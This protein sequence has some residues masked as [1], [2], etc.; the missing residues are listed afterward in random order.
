MEWSEK[1]F[2]SKK[3]T[4]LLFTELEKVKVDFNLPKELK[5]QVAMIGLTETDIK[6]LHVLQPIVDKYIDV[7]VEN[8]YDTITKEPSLI[9]IIEKHCNVERL[10]LTLNKHVLQIFSGE[11]NEEYVNHRKRIAHVHVRIGLGTKWYLN[12]FQHLMN[13]IYSLLHN[14]IED[15]EELYDAMNSIQ[16]IFS[17]EQQLVLESYENKEKAIQN[18]KDVEKDKIQSHMIVTAQE[19]SSIAEQTSSSLQNLVYQ[20]K[21]IEG[22]TDESNNLIQQV[23]A[24]SK[25]G[26]LLMEKDNESAKSLKENIKELDVEISDL[27]SLSKKVTNVVDVVS[28]IA[29][30]INLLALNATIES[31]HA[32]EHGKGFAVVANE[33][34]NLSSLTKKSTEDIA[35]LITEI[36]VQIHNVNHSVKKFNENIERNEA[37]TE[38]TLRFFNEIVQSVQQSR[39]KSDVIFQEIKESDSALNQINTSTLKVSE[40]ADNLLNVK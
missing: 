25:E 19:L 1:M 8:F 40:T 7:L 36:S 28:S 20:F 22:L 24:L 23:E 26:K 2:F 12:A 35:N 17:L 37:I 33:V 39:E 14:E 6:R 30:Q 16:K 34:R 21:N 9:E 10:S 4:P 29:S 27:F 5:T 32:G 11:V 3:K 13:T 15:K 38:S 18:E 31:A